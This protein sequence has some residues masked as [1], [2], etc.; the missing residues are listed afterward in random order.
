MK[1]QIRTFSVKE[2]EAFY[3][4][5][6]EFFKKPKEERDDIRITGV[7]EFLSLKG[8]LKDAI[9]EGCPWDLV[10]EGVRKFVPVKLWPRRLGR[11][12]LPE[13][14][15]RRTVI[16]AGEDD[17][18]FDAGYERILALEGCIQD[19]SF[20]SEEGDEQG[21]TVFAEFEV[22]WEPQA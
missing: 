17:F 19:V 8:S 9:D 11:E 22:D 18:W 21:P 2:R 16:N 4:A 1:L 7:C 10:E 6:L 20:L 15:R 12:I 3:Q 5:A 14:W 13:L